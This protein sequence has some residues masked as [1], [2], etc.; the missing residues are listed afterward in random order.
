[1][2]LRLFATTVSLLLVTPAFATAPLEPWPPAKTDSVTSPL[3][4]THGDQVIF[5]KTQIPLDPPGDLALETTFT[6][7]DAI[8]SRP[9]FADSMANLLRKRGWKCQR[10]SRERRMEVSVNGGAAKVLW[11]KLTHPNNFEQWRTTSF[12]GDGALAALDGPLPWTDEEPDY[13]YPFATQIVPQLKEG[14]NSVTFA[15]RASCLAAPKDGGEWAQQD[16][17][18]AAATLTLE[19]A[20]GDIDAFYAAKGPRLPKATHGAGQVGAMKKAM[21]SAEP[22]ATFV[23]ARQRTDWEISHRPKEPGKAQR[24]ESRTFDALVVMRPVDAS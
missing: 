2:M 22:K 3:F 24:Y 21:R 7:R 23:A 19:V 1:M 13:R 14:P 5:S 15:L 17:E 8:Y 20:A 9:I 6:L 12:G 18:V 16:F 11:H 4:S 10:D